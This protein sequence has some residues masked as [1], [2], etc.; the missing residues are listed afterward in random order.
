VNSVLLR[1]LRSCCLLLCIACS[2]IRA[3]FLQ[4]FR[5]SGGPNGRIIRGEE[6]VEIHIRDCSHTKESER[7]YD[8]DRM[9]SPKTRVRAS[10]L[11]KAGI[12][13]A[14]RGTLRHTVSS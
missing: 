12:R 7:L 14:K 4:S 10:D 3:V 5:L 9:V 11:L 13:S 2:T 1:F 8:E 6:V